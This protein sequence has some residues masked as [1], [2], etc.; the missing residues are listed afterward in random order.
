MTFEVIDADKLRSAAS[1]ARAANDGQ[2]VTDT[3]QDR[4]PNEPSPLDAQLVG[5]KIEVRWCYHL[6]PTPAASTPAPLHTYIWHE[7]VVEKVADGKSD[8]RSERTYKLLP[9]GALQLKCPADP[10]RDEPASFTWTILHPQKWSM[11]V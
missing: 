7:A 9:A 8:T 10:D 2:L 3:V 6:T 1:A 11:D 4:Q 5:Y